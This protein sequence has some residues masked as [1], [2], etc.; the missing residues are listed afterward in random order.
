LRGI[1]A[2]GAGRATIRGQNFSAWRGGYR[3]RYGSGWRTFV[4]LSVLSPLVFGYTYYYPYAYIS[5]PQ[6]YCEGFTEDGCQLS[7]QGVETLEGGIIYQCVAYCPW[8]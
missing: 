2:I 4:A 1:P 5:A 3:V 8:Q 6:P 7:W